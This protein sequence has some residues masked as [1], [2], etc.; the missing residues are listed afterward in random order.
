MQIVPI[1]SGEGNGK[2]NINVFS[3]EGTKDIYLKMT[4][5]GNDYFLEVGYQPN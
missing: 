5:S 4:T 3:L 1:A 2:A